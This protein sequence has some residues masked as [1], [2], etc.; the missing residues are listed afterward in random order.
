[1]RE[2]RQTK[3]EATPDAESVQPKKRRGRRDGSRGLLKALE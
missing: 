3:G 1:M 2:D